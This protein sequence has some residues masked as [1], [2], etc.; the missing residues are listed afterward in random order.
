MN[1]EVTATAG[2]PPVRGEAQETHPLIKRNLS[3]LGH[4][5][6]QLD[7]LVGRASVSVER[8]FS[9]A[10]GDVVALDA[11]IDEPVTIRLDGKVVAMGHLVA[12]GD[13]F[14]VKISEI[15]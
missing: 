3:L 11:G 4:V 10:K 6:V 2:V 9:L 12:V 5:N 8:L 14:G 13:Q 1:E 15:L 7:V